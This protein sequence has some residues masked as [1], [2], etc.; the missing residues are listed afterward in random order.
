MMIIGYFGDGPWSHLSLTKILS[1]TDVKVAFVCARFDNPDLELKRLADI[2]GIPFFVSPDVNEASFVEKIIEVKCDLLIS[3][4]FN[5]IFKSEILNVPRLGVINCHA[6]MLPF[7]RGRNVLNWALINDESSFGITVHYVDE[8]IDTGDII[9]QEDFPITDEDDYASLLAKAYQGCAQVLNKS[10]S[11]IVEGSVSVTKQTDIHP[12]G[13]YC[14]VRKNGDEIVNWN[15]SSRS[16]FNFVRA[17]SSP[18]PNARSS[19]GSKELVIHKALFVP[20]AP[21]YVGIP[22]TILA[23]DE[24]RIAVK[25]LDSFIYIVDWEVEGKLNVGDRLQ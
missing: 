19:C 9:R 6:G 4:S 18:G 1:R 15:Q 11:D 16:I 2:N 12:L 25:T 22:G 24:R 5:Q 13:F 3:M 7:Y 20:D 17:L 14:C 21:V 8:G 23:R 10:L